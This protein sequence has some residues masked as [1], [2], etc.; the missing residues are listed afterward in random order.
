ML[1][2]VNILI[3]AFFTLADG[4][5]R[6][7]GPLQPGSSGEASA[8]P[9]RDSPF[10]LRQ[11]QSHGLRALW[12]VRARW[13][14]GSPPNSVARCRTAANPGCRKAGGWWV[15]TRRG[16]RPRRLSSARQCY[17]TGGASGPAAGTCPSALRRSGAGREVI[18]FQPVSSFANTFRTS[19]R[20]ST[21][22]RLTSIL[23]PTS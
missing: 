13:G 2:S 5:L 1:T 20:F 18:I 22:S 23:M 7:G 12:A 3:A 6:L 4:E 9:R 19:F 11:A 16:A 10:R 17:S 14:L 15:A 8:S 21:P